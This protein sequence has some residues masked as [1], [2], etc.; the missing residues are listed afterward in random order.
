MRTFATHSP[1]P[2]ALT[3]TMFTTQ[4]WFRVIQIVIN[5][6]DVQSYAAKTC[7]EVQI[8]Q[9]IIAIFLDNELVHLCVPTRVVCAI[10]V[11]RLM[12]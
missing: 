2:L 10:S 4:V 12:L 3:P 11:S 1:R 6:Q 9:I 7:F 5:R 8:M